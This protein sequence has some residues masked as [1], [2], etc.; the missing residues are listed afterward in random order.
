MIDEKVYIRYF[1]RE[2]NWVQVIGGHLH[3]KAC[4]FSKKKQCDLWFNDKKS[5]TDKDTKTRHVWFY[6]LRGML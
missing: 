6:T 2:R 1:K 3:P 5:A 4:I